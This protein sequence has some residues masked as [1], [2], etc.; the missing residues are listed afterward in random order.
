VD[1]RRS[2]PRRRPGRSPPVTDA[3]AEPG[4]SSTATA[5]SS[6]A[7]PAGITESVTE[8]TTAKNDR[9][10]EPDAPERAADSVAPV[11]HT[12]VVHLSIH[13]AAPSATSPRIE[14]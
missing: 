14:R 5:Q 10:T 8:P 9:G 6:N 13:P 3:E 7:Q 1:A 11:G 12:E 2:P 4:N